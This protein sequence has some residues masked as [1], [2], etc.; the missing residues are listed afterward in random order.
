MAYVCFNGDFID[1]NELKFTD[2]SRMRYADSI[3]E[4]MLWY[5]GQIPL[6]SYHLQRL[7]YSAK[8]M[9]LYFPDLNFG[10]I[11]SG[12]TE[13]NEYPHQ[14]LR[15]RMTL[16]RNFGKLYAPES[17]MSSY[18]I[19]CE[20]LFSPLFNVVE[21][22]GIYEENRKS[23]DAMSNLKSGNS[24]I[25]VLAKQFANSHGWDDALILNAHNH[26]IEA[27]SSNL[28]MVKNNEIY[29]P[30]LSS[31]CVNGVMR[32]FIINEF[33]VQER[34]LRLKEINNADEVFL[35]NAILLVQPVISFGE[36]TFIP[37]ISEEIISFTKEKLLNEV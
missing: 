18:L 32:N 25:Y 11:I 10:E 21:K 36:H 24:L 27:T 1:S 30:P 2:F 8:Y 31:G 7:L 17:D 14:V 6:A 12:L 35:T 34:N 33:E 22:L 4:S 20:P 5:N 26:V 13:L 3:F 15:I 37:S 9:G 16:F 19:E 23:A 29:T 28:F